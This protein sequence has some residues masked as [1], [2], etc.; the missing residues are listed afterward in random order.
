MKTQTG[1]CLSILRKDFN[2]TQKDVA[3]ILRVHPQFVSLIENGHSKMPVHSVVDLLDNSVFMK[4]KKQLK[5]RFMNS[6]ML[7]YT[8]HLVEALK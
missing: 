5:K 4:K 8:S 6:L 1:K 2:L 7:D 3:K